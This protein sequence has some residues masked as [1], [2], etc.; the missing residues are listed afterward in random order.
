[1]GWNI[2]VIV[3]SLASA[4][5]LI[6]FILANV[7]LN[8]VVHV[9]LLGLATALRVFVVIVFCTIVWVPL[10]VWIGLRPN[11]A[12]VAQPLMQFLAAFPA[13]LLFPVVVVAIVKFHLN[14]NI[15]V[16]P[17][18]NSSRNSMVCCV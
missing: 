8:E 15:W 11:V 17:L 3:A 2:L 5:L 9:L 10:G 16:T 1:M 13:Y 14:V 4:S 6:H 7:T 12:R 18:M